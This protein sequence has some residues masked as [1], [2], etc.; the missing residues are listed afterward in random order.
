MKEKKK[1]TKSK[2]KDNPETTKPEKSNA[3][4]TQKKQEPTEDTNVEDT[5]VQK[6]ISD[7]AKIITG[8]MAL[9][10]KEKKLEEEKKKAI[11]EQKTRIRK[12]IV[13]GDKQLVTD[14]DSLPKDP[15]KVVQNIKLFEWDA[16]IRIKFPFDKKTFITIV[17]ISLAFV[18]YLAILGHYWLM[19][20]IIALLFF[21]YVAGTT[22]PQE[23]TH[24]ITAR[25]IDSIGKLYEW[26]MLD[27]F[28]F[29][30]KNGQQ[31]LIVST[32]L[33]LPAKL[34]MV[35]DEKDRTAIFLLLHDKLLYKDIRKQSK[36]DISTYGEYIP[37]EK[38]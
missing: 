38:I 16:P 22:E 20:S 1:T 29:T 33:R 26:Y 4:K 34:M 5:K 35:L 27:Q 12:E 6:E 23:V 8:E 31:L 32:N 15:E 11:E 19:A 30:E 9:E 21:V 18:L 28:W 14:P 13:K 37:L 3:K 24:K 2:K 25:G 7:L 36:V 10:K 17:A